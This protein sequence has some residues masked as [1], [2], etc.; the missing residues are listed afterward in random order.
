MGY[1][2][3][4]QHISLQFCYYYYYLVLCKYS[5]IYR[6]NVNIIPYTCLSPSQKVSKTKSRKKTNAIRYYNE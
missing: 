5:Y 3:A 1:N 2:T 6:L 4:R